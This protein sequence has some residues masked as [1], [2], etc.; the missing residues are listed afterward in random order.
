MDYNE[1]RLGLSQKAID[2]MFK[3]D[4]DYVLRLVKK[5]LRHEMD[6]LDMW[7]ELNAWQQNIELRLA[8]QFQAGIISATS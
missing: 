1:I 8:R 7:S 2:L 6:D 4:P 5:V 3:E